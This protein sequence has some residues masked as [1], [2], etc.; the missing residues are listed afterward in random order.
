L[1]TFF[2]PRR[3]QDAPRRPQDG[4]K[5]PQDAPKTPQDAPR[6][7]KP[8]PRHPQGPQ[9][10]PQTT[11]FREILKDFWKI[12]WKTFWKNPPRP[13]ASGRVEVCMLLP[14]FLLPVNRPL[15][16]PSPAAV[17]G[18]LL[19]PRPGWHP[20]GDLLGAFKIS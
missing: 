2:E 18:V 7:P 3:P 1:A 17:L 6:R 8:P 16:Y 10:H 13:L 12:F 9:N 14:V 19:A 15:P 11:I 5:T 20:P 4:P